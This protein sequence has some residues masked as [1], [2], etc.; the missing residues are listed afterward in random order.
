MKQLRSFW[1]IGLG[2]LILIIG[3]SGVVQSVLNLSVEDD[4]YDQPG[5]EELGFVPM[6]MPVSAAGQGSEAPELVVTPPGPEAAASLTKEAQS[7]TSAPITETSP[8]PTATVQ[9]VV[10]ERITIEKINLDA[11]IIPALVKKLKLDEIV[12]E[13]WLAPDEYAVGWHYNTALLGQPGNT[14]LNG[15]HNIDGMV[16]EN[17]HQL[18]PGDIIE[19]HGEG[20][21]FS[22]MVVNVMI[23]PERG[24]EFT[25]RL[26]NARWLLPSTDERVTLITC[27]PATSNTHRLIVVA[28][29]H[30]APEVEPAP[31]PREPE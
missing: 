23:L 10:P 21:K 6:A 5:M 4:D 9:P 18:A 24:Q 16:F 31:T 17:L 22:Y 3:L 30:G 19:L 29:P 25:I 12:Y 11:P 2:V 20:I 28:R 26:D 27:W 15:H 13:Q 14:V 1:I 8:T 7:A